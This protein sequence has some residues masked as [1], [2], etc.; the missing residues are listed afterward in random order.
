MLSGGSQEDVFTL[1]AALLD[2]S[3]AKGVSL[4]KLTAPVPPLSEGTGGQGPGQ[5]RGAWVLG[6]H[7]APSPGAAVPE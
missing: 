3:S 1:C 7:L 2:P 4:W 5:R 6:P